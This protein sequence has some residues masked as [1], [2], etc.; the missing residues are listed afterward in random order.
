MGLTTWEN[1]PD[2]K[3][4]KSDV[5][6]PKNHLSQEELGSLGRIVNAYLE[7]ASATGSR[8]QGLCQNL[9]HDS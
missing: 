8:C 3:A 6:V 4:R 7:L 2:G 1:P 5:S 9:L